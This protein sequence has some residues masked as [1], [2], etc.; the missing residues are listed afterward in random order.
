ML[1]VVASGAYAVVMPAESVSANP[2]C[3]QRFL[4]FPAWYN[5]ATNNDCEIDLSNNTS[6]DDLIR[7]I[8][9]I[10]FNLVEIVLQLVAYTTIVMLIKGGFDYILS[11][12]DSNKM[13]GAKS[14]IQNALI[15][16]IISLLAVAIVNVAGAAV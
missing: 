9:P 10:A 4:T 5:N 7:K 1:I 16:L 6:N 13:S 12:G 3:N 2:A 15:G 11:S 14:T 8:L